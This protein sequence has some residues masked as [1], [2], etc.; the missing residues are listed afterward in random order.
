MTQKLISTIFIDEVN[1]PEKDTVTLEA[2]RTHF[3]PKLTDTNS[4]Q[5]L[6]TINLF[7]K[8]KQHVSDNHIKISDKFG[9]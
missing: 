1:M 9:I 8:S 6:F 4:Q 2:V 7:S 5:H 3:E